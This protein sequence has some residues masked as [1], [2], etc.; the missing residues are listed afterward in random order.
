MLATSIQKITIC[1]LLTVLMSTYI[2]AGTIYESK[3]KSSSIKVYLVK[4]KSQ[5]DL[6]V[7]IAKHK[8]EAKG[9]DE[10]WYY[11]KNRSSA[12]AVICFVTSRSQAD[13]KVYI[14][15]SKSQAGWKKSNRYRGQLR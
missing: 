1:I 10:I 12:N 14:V 7:Y 2:M 9:K 3:T 13:I 6:S 8:I 15:S 4:T 11:V 5:A